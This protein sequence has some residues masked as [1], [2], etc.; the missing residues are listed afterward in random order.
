MALTKDAFMSEL[1]DGYEKHL[2]AVQEGREEA[3]SYLKAE[4][5]DYNDY[6]EHR[7]AWPVTEDGLCAPYSF[8]QP[9][10]EE[11]DDVYPLEAD[12]C[13]ACQALTRL[14]EKAKEAHGEREPLPGC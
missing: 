1:L 10:C 6:I 8:M 4:G 13:M 3:Y 5:V 12:E 9:C 14:Y 2:V 7:H 11:H